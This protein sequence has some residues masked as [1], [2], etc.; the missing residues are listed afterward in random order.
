M[1]RLSKQLSTPRAAVLVAGAALL[2]S[3][4]ETTSDPSKAGLADG[5]A[6]L[7][8]G[9]YEK[10]QDR[11]KENLRDAREDRNRW[12]NQ[13]AR[14]KAENRRLE[15]EERELQVQ[16]G[17]MRRKIGQHQAKV[18]RM[19]QGGGADPRK[20]RRV[21]G[22]LQALQ[23]RI[24]RVQA[25]REPTVKKQQMM[26]SIQSEHDALVRRTRNFTDLN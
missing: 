4:C 5:I 11:L 21:Q 13:A 18:A 26:S 3:A 2:L 19:Q 16:M 14:M 10:R 8:T 25:S 23:A 7:A 20:V 22:E 9:K 15:A 6:N 17:A 24:N 1:T 12:R